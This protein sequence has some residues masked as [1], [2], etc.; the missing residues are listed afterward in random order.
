MKKIQLSLLFF[1]LGWLLP[2]LGVEVSEYG[3]KAAYLFNFTKFVTWPPGTF[4][5]ENSPVVIGILGDDPFGDDLDDVVEGKSV[6]QHPI[7]VIR[8]GNFEPSLE[9]PI[10]GCQILFI[11][12]SEKSRLREI[13]G[14]LKGAGVLTVSEI[15]KFPLFGGEILFDQ[16]GKRIGL[17]V[18][19]KAAQRANLE[20]SAKLLQV[21]KIYKPE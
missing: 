6:N 5:D 20:I 7:K 17:V 11:A 18:N 2:A 16:V 4:A 8:F 3:V 12:Y 19:P 10:R 15:D 1:L 9:G 14:A 13:L 21:S